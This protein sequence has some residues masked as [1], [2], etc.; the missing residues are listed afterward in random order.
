MSKAI[1]VIFASGHQTPAAGSRG[2]PYTWGML[3][4]TNVTFDAAF[5]DA[6]Q[7]K[8]AKLGA[9]VDAAVRLQ[10]ADGKPAAPKHADGA[11]GIVPIEVL[12]VLVSQPYVRNV[13]VVDGAGNPVKEGEKIVTRA[14]NTIRMT[15]VVAE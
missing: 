14:E 6:V 3:S 11:N 13:P 1:A 4:D 12:D 10:L 2:I 5:G 9:K 8:A 15:L 7:A